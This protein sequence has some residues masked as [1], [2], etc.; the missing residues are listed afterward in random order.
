MKKVIVITMSIWLTLSLTQESHGQAQ[1]PEGK[2]YPESACLQ[3]EKKDD[4][5]ITSGLLEAVSVPINS[6]QVGLMNGQDWRLGIKE[7]GSSNAWIYLTNSTTGF[8]VS[9]GGFACTF[10]GN[11]GQPTSINIQQDYDLSVEYLSNSS[12]ITVYSATISG[13]NQCMFNL[14][15]FEEILYSDFYSDGD[16]CNDVFEDGVLTIAQVNQ[17]AYV[18]FTS[19]VVQDYNLPVVMNVIAYNMTQNGSVGMSYT[20]E[21][22][23][24]FPAFG[25]NNFGSRKGAWLPE[26]TICAYVIFANPCELEEYHYSNRELYQMVVDGSLDGCEYCT[27]LAVGQFSTD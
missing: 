12:W 21:N 22:G 7:S 8:S 2:F 16:A 10:E 15:Y 26:S 23:Q 17:F 1:V 4:C 9:T 19:P 13:E 14:E 11:L 24:G 18:N 3:V 20:L 27:E 5:D 25:A 6:W